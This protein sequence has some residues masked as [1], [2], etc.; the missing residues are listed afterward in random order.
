MFK[1]V[2][3]VLVVLS[4]VLSLFIY[5]WFFSITTAVLGGLLV[6]LLIWE[7]IDKRGSSSIPREEEESETGITVYETNEEQ[8]ALKQEISKLEEQLEAKDNFQGDAFLGFKRFAFSIPIVEKLS[9]IIIKKSENSTV[10]VTNSIFS[11]A[12]QSKEVGQNIEDMLNRLTSGSTGLQNVT[13]ELMEGVKNFQDLIGRFKSI[14]RSYHEDMGV[15][16][17]TVGQINNFTEDITDLADQTSILAINA[18]IEAARVGEKGKGFAV[19]AGEVQELSRKSKNIADQINDRIKETAVTVDESFTK[20]SEHIQS[21]IQ[22]MEESQSSLHR[23]SEIILK[24][25][26]TVTDSTKETEKLSGTVTESLNEVITSLQF[27]DI[28]RQ[29]TEHIMEVLKEA[30]RNCEKT[31]QGLQLENTLDSETVKEEVRKQASSYFSVKEE[32]EALDMGI[33]EDQTQGTQE[34]EDEESGIEELET[35]ESERKDLQGDVT[36]F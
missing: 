16:E 18:S 17:E 26:Q 29:V 23:V 15:I 34:R 33:D 22:V 8:E 24:Q 7:A 19:I 4:A 6:I 10:E 11:I 12:E 5:P 27:Q 35:K 21:A 30:E 31:F 32:W 2:F 3:S 28:I 13:D 9:E 14:S 1:I 36:L 20:Q 25:T